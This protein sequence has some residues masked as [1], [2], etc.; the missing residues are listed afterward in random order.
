MSYVIRLSVTFYKFM[1]AYAGCHYVECRYAEYH[2][3]E[4]RGAYFFALSFSSLCKQLLGA[5][6]LSII[7]LSMMAN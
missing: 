4:C 2:Y 1:N 5:T 3:T 7:T 6:P